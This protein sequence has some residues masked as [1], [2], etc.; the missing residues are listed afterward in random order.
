M[1][2]MEGI[3]YAALIAWYDG[4]F[5]FQDKGIAGFL[6]KVGTYSYSIY[7]LHFFFVF[8]ISRAI[9]TQYLNM[10]NIYLAMAVS[11]VIFFV[12]MVPIAYLSY[13]FIESPFLR[14]RNKYTMPM[15]NQESSKE[16]RV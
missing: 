15:A 9:H 1:S 13:R 12:M 6:A 2:T 8:D 11:I 4:S 5:R 10:G 16:S 14:F 3:A 7:L